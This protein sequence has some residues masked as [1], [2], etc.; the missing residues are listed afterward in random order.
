MILLFSTKKNDNIWYKEFIKIDKEITNILI[1]Y[2]KSKII[3]NKIN[4]SIYYIKF[5]KINILI[6]N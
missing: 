6:I 1:K 5:K 3:K 4:F 2:K